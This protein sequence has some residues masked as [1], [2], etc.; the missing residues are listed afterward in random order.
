MNPPGQSPMNTRSLREVILSLGG[1]D[2]HM[3]EEAVPWARRYGTDWGRALAVCAGRW[4]L[5]L[6]AVALL[7][8]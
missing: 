2:P 6:L 4:V 5:G 8:R 1:R 7:H 3:P